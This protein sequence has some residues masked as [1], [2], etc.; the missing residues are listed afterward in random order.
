M[1][2]GA[3][4]FALFLSAWG[5]C[6]TAYSQPPA[7]GGEAVIK[8]ETNLVQV[9]VV[10]R[11][12]QG[13]AVGNLQIQDFR[14]FDN[15]KEQHISQFEVKQNQPGENLKEV[16][17]RGSVPGP[18]SSNTVPP[19]LF[20]AYLVD[21]AW[22]TPE[23]FT[24]GRKAALRH[25]DTLRPSDRT[26]V[27]S[28]SDRVSLDFTSDRD[29]VRKT[30][31]GLNSLSRVATWTNGTLRCSPM[32]FYKAD[33]IADG[34]MAAMRDCEGPMDPRYAANH[35]AGQPVQPRRGN[36][37]PDPVAAE[38]MLQAQIRADAE[39]VLRASERDLKTYLGALNV[40]VDRM[41]G[42]P[43]TREI[44]I[45]SPGVYVPERFQGMQDTLLNKAIRAK[46]VISAVDVRG[47]PIPWG[48]I[49]A[50]DPTTGVD[51]YGIGEKAEQVA[52][53]TQLT[54]GTGGIFLRGNN[55]LDLQMR[56]AASIPEYVY[57][58]GFSPQ[59]LKTDGKLHALRISVP[60][61]RRSTVQARMNYRA[62]D[63]ARNP[64]DEM[65]QGAEDAFFSGEETPG[66][67]VQ[68]DASFTRE[69]DQ[70]KLT[71]RAGFNAADLKFRQENGYNLA[72]VMVMVGFF[73]KD[74]KYVKSVQKVYHLRLS[75]EE[76]KKSAKI[77][78]ETSFDVRPEKYRIRFVARDDAGEVL[79]H[80]QY[81][82]VTW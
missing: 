36:G 61:I 62:P 32:T 44:V 64:M 55:D 13:H 9:P 46:V 1:K 21:D 52:T 26:A 78:A 16:N 59:N 56:R 10:V 12:S 27:Y 72:D 49:G 6:N 74:E 71:I 77:Q 19:D 37:P 35:A 63:A 34:D 7:D 18:R 79:E 38:L 47:V 39:G 42:L 25:L 24:Y 11:N 51:R 80:S 4:L 65:R 22:L 40:L 60:K 20:I 50:I 67:P 70:A 2:N 73:D 66:T 75:D 33:L 54:E 58:L 5:F 8:S 29:L 53:M 82:D 31:L 81:V 48:T 28:T 43:G 76:V 45:L 14:L 17:S 68:L 30:L 57:V 3:A 15:G 69:M 23:D 41:A